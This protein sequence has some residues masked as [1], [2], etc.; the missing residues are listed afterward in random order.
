[1]RLCSNRIEK[2][3]GQRTAAEGEPVLTADPKRKLFPGGM[4]SMNGLIA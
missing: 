4:V 3:P 1:M 2:R